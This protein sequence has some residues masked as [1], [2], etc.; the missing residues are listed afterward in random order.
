MDLKMGRQ[1][2]EP[3][4]PAKKKV[5][6]S[7]LDSMSTSDALGFRICGMRVYQKPTGEF[8]VRDKPWGMGVTVDKME[9]CL[10]EYIENGETLRYE[11]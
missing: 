9:D 5:E 11:V 6:Q 7:A 2:Y 8:R 1:T 4:A 10:K 3:S